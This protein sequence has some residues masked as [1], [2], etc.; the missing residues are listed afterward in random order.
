LR[1][2]GKQFFMLEMVNEKAKEHISTLSFVDEIEVYLAF[3]IALKE[4][5]QLPINTSNMIFR[6]CAQIT[7]DE[8]IA[9]GDAIEEEYSDEKL[10]EFLKTWSPWIE[11]LRKDETVA[12]YDDLLVDDQAEINDDTICS[13]LQEAPEQPVSYKGAIYDYDSFVHYYEVNGSNP[14]NPSEE[15][16]LTLLRRVEKKID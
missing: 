14:M 8:L 12:N 16:D 2:L 1:A 4:R 10:D 7:D 6:N 13:I 5:L 15:I 9:V 11:F 3:R